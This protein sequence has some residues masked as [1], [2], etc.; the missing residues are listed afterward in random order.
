MDW[1]RFSFEF[2]L[3]KNFSE[4]LI[5]IDAYRQAVERI[6]IPNAWKT[7]LNRLNRI[8]SIHGTSAIEGNLMSE[9]QVRDFLERESREIDNKATLSPDQLQIQNAERA[10]EWIRER[11]SSHSDLSLR[12]ENLLHLHKL[13]T[14]GEHNA[15]NTPGRLRTKRVVVG[16]KELGGVHVGAPQDRLGD[17]LSE[18]LEWLYSRETR[19]RW[20]P[21]IRALLAHF[22]LVTI[23]PFGDG[24]GRLSRLVEAYLLLVGGYNIHGFYGLSNFFYQ[25]ADDYKKLLQHSRR[26]RPFDLT[27]FIEFGLSG[28]EQELKGINSF[29]QERQNR[30]MF[31][32]TL[33]RTR[34]VRKSARRYVL[35]SRE[36]DFLSRLVEKTNPVDPF[37]L[38]TEKRVSLSE[39]QSDS[40]FQRLYDKVSSRTFLREIQQLHEKEFV[41]L[42]TNYDNELCVSIDLKAIE[43][44]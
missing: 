7:E 9:D 25:N 43:R 28:F 22:F 27:E 35:S 39:I 40:T 42:T 26:L 24:N 15:E 2:K 31:I 12:L 10:Q 3:N 11:I 29:I 33:N 6:Y 19:E 8:R 34:S 16:S 1:D 4:L 41:K 38:S 36:Y 5:S 30:M 13:I 20:H 37:T 21:V 14:D 18:F 44:Y 32:D 17:L 23:H